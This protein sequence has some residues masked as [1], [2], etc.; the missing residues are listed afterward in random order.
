MTTLYDVLKDLTED[1]YQF[2]IALDDGAQKWFAETL[3]DA[4]RNCNDDSLERHAYYDNVGI[5]EVEEGC[6]PSLIYRAVSG[7]WNDNGEFEEGEE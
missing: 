1:D 3:L 2:C 4:L 7:Q 6:D 5:W